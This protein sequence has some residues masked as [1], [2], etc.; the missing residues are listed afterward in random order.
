MGGG[1]REYAGKMK[2]GMKELKVTTRNAT[3][4]IE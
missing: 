1:I 4:W 2:F 3:S